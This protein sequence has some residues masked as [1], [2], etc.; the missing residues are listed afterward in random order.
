MNRFD[1]IGKSK[2]FYDFLKNEIIS[3]EYS[4]GDKFPS[5]RELAS[6]YNISSITV[7][8]VI[9]NLV[10]EGLLYVVQGRGTFV[11]EK[12]RE[13]KKK[14][15]M[16]GVMLF[17]FSLESNVEA[18][19]FNSIQQNLKDEYYVVPYNSYNKLEL[20]YKGIK[21]FSELEADG[22]ILIPPTSEDY[23]PAL[24]KSLIVPGIPVVFINRNIP[25]I[26]ADFL[27]MDF[28]KATF[29]AVKHLID[30]KRSKIILLKSD[31]AS[32]FKQMYN[33]YLR[34]H[35]EAGLKY[36]EE[37]FIEW[38]KSMDKAETSLKALLDRADGLVGSDVIIYKL[39]KTIY[40]AGI[41]IPKHFSVVGINDTVYSRF[42][43]PPLSAVP[44]PS[45][46]IGEAAVKA[47]KDKIEKV[48]TE[49]INKLFDSELI[50]RESS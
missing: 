35:E 50:V 46:E 10:T 1:T 42:M 43:N 20:F 49:D 41:K 4:E 31:S 28:D 45:E 2:Q 24:V 47:L 44:F 39:R 12:K 3:G 23:D 29:K 25:D 11:A 9:S 7:N 26:K 6:K 15:K 36:D 34:A 27:A 16:I 32:L 22:M 37:F 30:K 18:G 5:I 48:S 19:I 8:S 14:K 21:G 33:G 40:E 13:S 38:H 17:D